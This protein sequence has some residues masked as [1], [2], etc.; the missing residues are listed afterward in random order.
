MVRTNSRPCVLIVEDEPLIRWYAAQIIS[1]AGWEPLEAADADV[2]LEVIQ[3]NPEVKVL[4]TDVNM[5]GP[6]DGIQ[7]AEQVHKVRPDVEIV[8]TSGR[9]Q[10]R[11][12]ELPDDGTFIAKPY[13]ARELT[14]ALRA[15]LA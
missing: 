9:R 3:E 10:L 11:N 7:L 14:D 6:L 2:A 8:V 4:F 1:E 15:K 5:P 12:C 13:G